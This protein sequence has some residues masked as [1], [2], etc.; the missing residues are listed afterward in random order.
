ML[1]GIGEVELPGYKPAF[2]IRQA[3]RMRLAGG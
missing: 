3:S 2:N 1:K